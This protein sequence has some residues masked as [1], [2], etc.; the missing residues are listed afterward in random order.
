L[1]ISY[2]PTAIL[3]HQFT[4]DWKG[5]PRNSEALQVGSPLAGILG[6]VLQLSAQNLQPPLLPGA[7]VLDQRL[8]SLLPP[9]VQTLLKHE[10]PRFTLHI[11]ELPQ[12]EEAGLGLPLIILLTISLCGR[13]FDNAAQ[14]PGAIQMSWT[15]AWF[16]GLRLLPF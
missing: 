7:S 12:E 6:N 13:L 15:I 11:G 8:A 4:G 9:K 5:D 1:L 10:F 2:V 14:P 3:N 16:R